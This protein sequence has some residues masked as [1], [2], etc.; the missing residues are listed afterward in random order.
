MLQRHSPPADA[1]QAA[2]RMTDGRAGR[3]PDCD[4]FDEFVLSALGLALEPELAAD[5]AGGVVCELWLGGAHRG[6]LPLARQPG[7]AWE[8]ECLATAICGRGTAGS[9]PPVPRFV[10]T[11]SKRWRCACAAAPAPVAI[12]AARVAAE[13]RHRD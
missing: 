13:M 5:T 12:A 4:P 2:L 3:G 1:T 6:A 8:P 10:P 11:P 7:G 9:P